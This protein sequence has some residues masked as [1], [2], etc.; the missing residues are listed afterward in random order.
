[1]NEKPGARSSVFQKE[2]E[3]LEEARKVADAKD[4]SMDHLR[5]GYVDVLSK[6][7]R[8]L[9]EAKLLTSVSDRLHH[10]LNQ[11]N[12]KL[13]E[14]S[15]EINNINEDL[16][17]NN[18]ILQD[19][20][21]QLLRARVSRRAGTIVLIIAILLFL[22]SEGILEPLIEKETGDFYVGLGVKL[23]IALLLRPIDFLTEKY[24][25]RRALRT[26]QAQ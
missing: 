6:Y 17:V 20:I 14:Q 13:K 18:Q 2:L 26:A 3:F 7:E 22:V 24:L 25:M 10:K 12:D 5:H 8:L 15:E 1:M 4:P 23:V 16:K 21:D 19:T 9:G 11:A